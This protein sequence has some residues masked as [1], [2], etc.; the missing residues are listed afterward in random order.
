MLIFCSAVASCLRSNRRITCFDVSCVT[1]SVL[2]ACYREVGDAQTLTELSDV[3]YG[4]F[5]SRGLFAFSA[6]WGFIATYHQ[7][8]PYGDDELAE[9]EAV[10]DTKCR[11]RL[12]QTLIC[13]TK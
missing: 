6:S 4:A 5:A 11:I 8:A 1:M 9:P 7:V 12:V 2:L 3:I 10:S 13:T